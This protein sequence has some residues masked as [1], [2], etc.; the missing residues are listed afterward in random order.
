[1]IRPYLSDTVNDHITQGKWTVY[2]GNT[3]IDY[4]TPAEWKIKLSMTI[5]F[6][7][8]K[9]FDEISTLHTN[10]HNTEIIIGGE[11]DDFIKKLFEFLLQKY[12][13]GLEEKMRGSDLVFDGVD[14]LCCKLYET[15]LNRGG[16]YIDSPEWLKKQQQIL[17]IMMINA[18][19]MLSCCIKS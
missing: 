7:S 9:D 12:Q 18:F 6:I 15:S 19:N 13:E 1:M 8:S 14:L 3:V 2:S 16:S 11:T 17:Q 5:N 4:K 10:S